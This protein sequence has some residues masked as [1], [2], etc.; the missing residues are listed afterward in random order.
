MHNRG[1]DPGR[2]ASRASPHRRV[3]DPPR[4]PRSTIQHSGILNDGENKL[5][6]TFSASL[7]DKL[8]MRS[9]PT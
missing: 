7:K 2:F 4:S 5:D 9:S 6:A 3:T 8:I 1:F